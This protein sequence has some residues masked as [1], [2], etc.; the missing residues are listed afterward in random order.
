MALRE[1]HVAIV[2]V[3]AQV[4]VDKGGSCAT[5]RLAVGG[6]VKPTRL[7]FVEETLEREGLGDRVLSEAAIR[8]AE[9]VDPISDFHASGAYRRRLTRVLVGRALTRTTAMARRIEKTDG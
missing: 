2:E 6:C 5:A 9:L 7:R 8:A 1:N 3:A 4:T